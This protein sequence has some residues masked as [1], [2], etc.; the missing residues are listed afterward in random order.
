[1]KNSPSLEHIYTYTL[2]PSWAPLLQ[3]RVLLNMCTHAPQSCTKVPAQAHSQ[4]A[5]HTHRDFTRTAAHLLYQTC[6][7]NARML[8]SILPSGRCSHIETHPH[9]SRSVTIYPHHSFCMQCALQAYDP[10]RYLGY[11]KMQPRFSQTQSRKPQQGA[12]TP[13]HGT[14]LHSTFLSKNMG[15]DLE[16]GLWVGSFNWAL[17][18]TSTDGGF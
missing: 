7:T 12:I 11:M 5:S 3:A 18:E 17:P 8:F 16:R 9:L 6:P 14:T 15:P 1:M 10:A 4:T 2:I 13:Y